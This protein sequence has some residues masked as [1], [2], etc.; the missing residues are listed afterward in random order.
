MDGEEWSPLL[1]ADTFYR[2]MFNRVTSSL[3]LAH[4]SNPNYFTFPLGFTGV[5]HAYLISLIHKS[6]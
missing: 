4:W 3:P 5:V 6:L 2:V 1:G